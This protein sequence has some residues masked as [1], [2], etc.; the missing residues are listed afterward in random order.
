[1]LLVC[2]AALA[3]AASARAAGWLAP[4]TVGPVSTG[5]SAVSA[6]SDARGDVVAAWVRT[7]GSSQIVEVA[8][9]PAGGEFSVQPLQS[10]T[11]SAGNVGVAVNGQ[12]DA[13]VVWRRSTTTNEVWTSVRPAGGDFG[14]PQALAAVPGKNAL[15]PSVAV[16]DA[17]AMMVVWYLVNSDTDNKQTIYGAYRPPG[18]GFT[19]TPIST[20]DAWNQSPRVVLDS[21]G[22]ATVVWSYWDGASINI[23]RV[24]I[25]SAD[26][27]LGTQRNLSATAPTGF[28]M[29]ATV[30]LDNAGNALAVW[31]HW[32]GIAFDVE[33]AS[34]PAA[35]DSWTNLP[36]FGQSASASF[37]SE[38]QVA[39]DPSGNGLAVWRAASNTIQAASRAAGGAF[40]SAQLGISA[41]T[42]TTPRVV[43]DAAGNATSVWARSDGEGQ[44]IE[45]ATR[46]FGGQFGA[47]KVL[48]KP[49]S[50]LEPAL[51]MDGLGNAFSIWPLDDPS[52][53]DSADSLV[54]FSAYDSSPP[55]LNAVS[56]PAAGIAGASSSFSASASDVWSPVGVSWTFGDGSS[57][58]GASASHAYGAPGSYAVTVAAV[59]AAGNT[60]TATR[61]I[62]I[63][64]PPAPAPPQLKRAGT[65]L[66]F[67]AKARKRF[68]KLSKLQ[69]EKVPK[70]SSV[71]VTCKVGG[72][73][74]AGKAGRKFKRKKASGTVPLRAYLNQRFTPRTKISITVTNPGFIGELKILAIRKGKSPRLTTKCL[75]PGKRK[76]AACP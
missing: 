76:P 29:F 11:G 38:P 13:I 61:T 75:Q 43:L 63:S 64:N 50:A 31:S 56:V 12:G 9:R 15:E 41:P 59:D 26:G 73:K 8:S 17:G 58:D 22:K 4:T 28:P 74:C 51:S 55:D 19:T 44:R 36:S 34:R 5:V 72:E 20:A 7:D 45:A 32:N 18:G 57:A 35:A 46:P 10:A 69:L 33:G 70:G 62:Q 24:R 3:Q 71:V 14:P 40:G 37:G 53:P 16:N 65:K 42:A 60:R 6:G 25:R 39:V 27:S 48:S 1:M 66:T 68:T 54:Q 47:V 52:L 21:S 23:A 2:A 67:V 49:F 30:D